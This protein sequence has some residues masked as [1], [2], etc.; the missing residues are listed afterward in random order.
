MHPSATVACNNIKMT[1]VLKC[2]KCNI[3][4]D[5]MLSFI[6][7]KLSIMDDDSLVRICVASFTIDEIKKSKTLL[8]ESVPTDKRNILRK[9]KGKEHRDL[10][11]II[12]LL[13]VIDPD[14]TPIFVARQLEKLPPITFDHL[15]VTKLLKDITLLKSKVE[16]INSSYVSH[17][18]LKI[19]LCNLKH[20][21]VPLCSVTNN[22][23]INM[24]RG[25]GTY[26]DSGPI[27][28][29]YLSDSHS[30]HGEESAFS[31][32]FPKKSQ[33]LPNELCTNKQEGRK[34]NIDTVP[35][36]VLHGAREDRQP[37][38]ID[39]KKRL[40]MSPCSHVS[41]EQ[42]LI[43]T[44]AT[45]IAASNTSNAIY[46]QSSTSEGEWIKVQNRR[47][48]PKYRYLGQMGTSNSEDDGPFRAAER[49]T[50]IFITNI[51]KDTE[52][53]VIIKHIFKR[54]KQ[55]VSLQRI[56]MKRDSGHKAF[57]FF[58]PVSTLDLFLD[59]ALW[60]RG[61][62]FRRFV[63]YKQKSVYSDVLKNGVTYE[64]VR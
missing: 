21:S 59:G 26:I 62:I 31:S 64:N 7:N 16:N 58:V 24:R 57:K 9:Q 47:A 48:K 15:D 20:D 51:H 13:K 40:I 18:Q 46:K 14:V 36:T 34:S 38:E 53:Q 33:I 43:D 32:P 60:P 23:N 8:F 61:I 55:T 54:T 50:P 2:D 41:S 49:K 63:H 45:A 27:G 42:Q 19:E 3:V 29:S 1:N 17:E 10:V 35:D 12:A 37:R 39:P 56:S 44:G 30:Q 5:E 52:E 25:G 11:D 6:Q 4:I 28:L 22:N